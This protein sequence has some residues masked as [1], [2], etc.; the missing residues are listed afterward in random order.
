MKKQK[1]TDD[2]TCRFIF[3]IGKTK[4]L[5]VKKFVKMNWVKV[6]FF[7]CRFLTASLGSSGPR[8]SFD[9]DDDVPNRSFENTTKP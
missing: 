9:D 2:F 7:T 1:A 3:L 5:Q 4:N 6:Q 8:N